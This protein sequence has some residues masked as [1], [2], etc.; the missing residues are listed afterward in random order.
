MVI[1][2]PSKDGTTVSLLFKKKLMIILNNAFLNF[3]KKS[4]RGCC[5]LS[6]SF[7]VPYFVDGK[8]CQPNQADRKTYH[9]IPSKQN[10]S[11]TLIFINIAL[12]QFNHWRKKRCLF[13][14]MSKRINLP[15]NFWSSAFPKS[16]I[17]ESIIRLY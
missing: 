8:I 10:V 11:I 7:L 15:T 6:R 1:K 3:Y 5:L 2:C 13:S 17:Q 12:K 16:I 9:R 14:R 4:Y